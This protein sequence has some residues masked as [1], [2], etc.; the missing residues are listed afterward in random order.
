MK[1]LHI[2]S[3]SLPDTV[4]GTQV[5]VSALSR[6]LTARG[7]D[8]SI[9]RHAREGSLGLY[10]TDWGRLGCAD[11][12]S[13]GNDFSD[14]SSFE[15]LY[16]NSRID[17]LFAEFLDDHAPDVAHVHHLTCLSTGILP[18]L[19]ER[20]V[21][22]VLSLWDFWLGCPR[23]QMIQDDL[24]LC[25]SFDRRVCGSCCRRLWPHLIDGDESGYELMVDYDRWIK[26][27]LQQVD[28]LATPSAHTRSMY[29][30]W[31]VERE[32]IEVVPCGLEGRQNTRRVDRQREDLR[33]GYIGSVIPSKGAH[34]L[35]EAV[36]QMPADRVSLDIHGA[37][38]SWHN[39][40]GYE[41]RL[42][43]LDQG[44]HR[45][46]L[47]GRYEP[48]QVSDILA[49][50]DVLV[51]PGVW[52]ETFCLTIREGFLAGVPVV[53]SRIGAMAEAIED[54]VTGVLVEPGDAEDLARALEALRSQPELRQRISDAA[55]AVRTTESMVDQFESLYQRAM[56]VT[57]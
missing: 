4:G 46:R 6:S 2:S 1:V 39:D 52:Y 10:E 54:G 15:W 49:E 18:L 7:H 33:V 27:Q 30:D 20:G 36:Q 26:E 29:L 44:T 35:I 14:C 11:V 37:I 42:R 17:E 32:D 57:P 5:M 53:V 13:V 31:G 45:I 24:T 51:V 48:A 40:S 3:F 43:Q 23:G 22:T 8:V 34:V 47:H 21:P 41:E 56:R 55:K 19:K 50:L 25:A 16:R 9:F 28:V 38:S 12:Y